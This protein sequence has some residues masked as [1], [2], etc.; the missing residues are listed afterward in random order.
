MTMKI[1]KATEN[2]VDF[3][4]K[5]VLTALDMDTSDI[6]WV[7]ASCADP[8][9]MYSWNKALIAEDA[10]KPIGCIISYRGVDYLPI[11]EYTWSRLWE[12]V[13]PEVIRKSAIETY[14]GE[15]YLDSLSVD[16]EYRG[17]GIGKDLMQ[18][19]IAEGSALGYKRFALL[20]AV[21]KPRL[22][23]YYASLGFRPFGEVNFFDHKYH[24]MV[25][26]AVKTTSEP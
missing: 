15:Y 24:R 10:G 14:P 25:M 4:A 18:A 5:T 19:A 2:D 23:D 7:R 16:P 21:E 11:R 12:G 13:D 3:V 1:R 20:V 9:S 22:K 8:K 17:K 26:E 6:G